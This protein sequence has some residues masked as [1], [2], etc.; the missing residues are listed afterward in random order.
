MVDSASVVATAPG[1]TTEKMIEKLADELDFHVST[2]T[3]IDLC[4]YE[5]E[6]IVEDPEDGLEALP[7]EIS[8]LVRL[9]RPDYPAIVKRYEEPPKEPFVCW[10]DKVRAH[11]ERVR[12]FSEESRRQGRE[13]IARNRAAYGLPR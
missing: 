4:R 3:P 10:R 12:A 13:L 7:E 11:E 2:D 6:L 9:Q 5:L 1:W 8:Y